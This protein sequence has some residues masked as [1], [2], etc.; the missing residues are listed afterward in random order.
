VKRYKTE[1][2]T[3]SYPLSQTSLS[4]NSYNIAMLQIDFNLVSKS[5][6]VMLLLVNVVHA[7]MSGEL[8]IVIDLLSG[9]ASGQVIHT[10]ASVIKQYNF[11][12]A[13]VL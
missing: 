1:Y 7:I 6:E 10:R 11:V 2:T 3:F 4:C 5:R 9:N 8:K 12:S 13:K